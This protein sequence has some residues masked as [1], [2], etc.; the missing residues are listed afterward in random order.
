MSDRNSIKKIRIVKKPKKRKITITKIGS[1]KSFDDKKISN[2]GV[3]K[4]E[5]H[6]LKQT[7][8]KKGGRYTCPKI[9]GSCGDYLAKRGGALCVGEP[10]HKCLKRETKKNNLRSLNGKRK[11]QNG[12]R[13]LSK[14]DIKYV[15]ELLDKRD[16]K[17]KKYKKDLEKVKQLKKNQIKRQN[18]KIKDLKYKIKELK[19]V[20]LLTAKG[21]KMVG[22]GKKGKYTAPGLKRLIAAS[23]DFAKKHAELAK[24]GVKKKRNKSRKK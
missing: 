7:K 8:T 17:N 9:G 21:M 14:K 4:L 1:E 20:D 10:L 22:A 13:E 18:K 16:K 12:G 11:N 5:K 23:P 19:K 15:K 2:S 6:K 24:G 3:M